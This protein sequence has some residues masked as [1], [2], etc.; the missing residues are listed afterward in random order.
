[1]RLTVEERRNTSRRRILKTG[2]IS[3]EGQSFECAVRN[4]SELGACLELTTPT[5]LP[6]NFTLFIKTAKMM[7]H[8]HQKPIDRRPSDPQIYGDY[9]SSVGANLAPR[10]IQDDASSVGTRVTIIQG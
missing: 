5:A 1:M 6:N 7:R 8:C 10:M 2:T 9:W 3:F 4:V